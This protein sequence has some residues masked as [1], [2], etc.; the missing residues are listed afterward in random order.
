M[1][2]RWRRAYLPQ[3]GGLATFRSLFGEQALIETDAE[4]MTPAARSSSPL[5]SVCGGF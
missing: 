5:G 3:Q 1:L 2:W 4:M